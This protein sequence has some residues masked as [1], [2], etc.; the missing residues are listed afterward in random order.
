MTDVRAA[1]L[2]EFPAP[3]PCPPW[4]RSVHEEA[5]IKTSVNWTRRHWL[6]SPRVDLK[7]GA[8]FKVSLIARDQFVGSRWADR[9]PGELLI[10]PDYVDGTDI[11]TMWVS[12]SDPGAV[13]ALLLMAR[14]ISPKVLAVV[15][16][17]VDAASSPEV[18][19]VPGEDQ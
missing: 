13:V 14:M 10:T 4:C 1:A 8:S 6:H 2:G 12:M 18:T 16:A 7:G 17:A 5:D 15:Q 3:P 11:G 19:P 9:A